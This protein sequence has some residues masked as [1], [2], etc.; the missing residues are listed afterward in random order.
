MTTWS[1]RSIRRLTSGTIALASGT[2]SAPPLQK[3]FCM[4]T[5]ISASLSIAIA[6]STCRYVSQG[7]LALEGGNPCIERATLDRAAQTAHDVLIVLKI[8]PAQQHRAE[9]LLAADQVMKVGAAVMDAG[10]A[11]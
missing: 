5:T 2:A 11:G 6:P 1:K 7:L 4:S 10:R 8:V 9:D 3:S